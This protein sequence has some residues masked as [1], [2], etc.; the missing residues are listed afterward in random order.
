MTLHRLEHAVVMDTDDIPGRGGYAVVGISRGVSQAE[1]A[2]LAGNFGISDYLQDPKTENRVFYSVFR[3]PGGRRA[4]VRRFPRG[5]ELRRNNTQRRLV[6]HTLLLEDAVW[7]DLYA[8]P[9]LLLNARVRAEGATEWDRLRS[10]VPWVDDSAALPP[11]EWDSADGSTSGVSQKLTSRLTVIGNQLGGRAPEPRDL[12]ARVLTAL[13]TRTRVALPQDP[14]YEWVTMLA[15]SMLPRHD[16]DELAWTQHDSLN[17]PGVVFPL[18]NAIAADFDPAQVRPAPFAR[19]L[20]AMNVESE[21]SWLDLQE[22]T[23]RHPLTVRQPSDLEAWVKWRD[24]LL[25]LHDNIQAPEAQVVASME[26]LAATASANRNAAWI[27]GEEVLRLVWSNVP[28]AI[29]GGLTAEVAVRTWGNRLRQSGLADVIFRAAPSKRWLTRA[30]GDVGADPLVWFFLTGGG[31][32]AASKATRAAIADWLIDAKIR[33]VDPARLAMLAYLLAAGRSPALQPLLE[34]LLETSAGLDALVDYLKRRQGGGVELMH[35]AAPIVLR[36]AHPGT[37]AFL[38]EVFVPRFDRGKVD[39]KLARDVATV[40]REDPPSF[41]RFLDA[42]SVPDDL[43]ALV[44]QWLSQD[45]ERTLPLARELLRYLMTSLESHEGRGDPTSVRAFILLLRPV[46]GEGGA[47]FFDTLRAL[48]E[49]SA[50]VTAWEQIVVTYAADHRASRPAA[51]SDLAATF[52]LKIDPSQLPSL[53][54]RTVALLDVVEGPGRTRLRAYW[55]KP[56]KL[57]SLPRCAAADRLLDLVHKETSISYQ[58]EMDLALR[59]IEQGVATVRTLNRLDAALA[60]L[61]SGKAAIVLAGEIDKYLG[62]GGAV[63]RMTRLLELFASGE[64][65]PTVRLVLQTRVLA[66]VLRELERRDWQELRGAARDEDLLA[67]GAVPRLAYAVGAHASRRTVEEFEATWRRHQRRDALD[68]LE[69]GRRTRGPLQWL[70][71]ATGAAEASL[72]AR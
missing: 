10:E 39:A 46:W 27:D 28:E 25:R 55:S 2:F 14:G 60:K 6:I 53:D 23:A 57:R 19:E 21:D 36:R 26:K 29:A 51:A 52:W 43:L 22:R 40:L 30:A 54:A 8:L 56:S 3:V 16:R 63:A 41:V 34:L 66:R 15:W 5:N 33:D 37:L 9:W 44:R 35:T 61:Q 20:V 70:A 38:R 48:V 32:D 50:L 24:A 4:F 72:L 12:L 65:L 1:R 11:L 59:D 58:V 71:R 69:A 64:L 49:R 31:E 7:N 18:A 45:A 42:R 13:G 68:A 47:A 62:D 17:L 67:L